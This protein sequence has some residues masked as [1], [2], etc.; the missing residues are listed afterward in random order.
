MYDYGA[1]NYDAAIGRWM[2][3]DPLAENS[4]RWTPY[5]YAYN[6]PMYFIDPDG[7]QADD[8]RINYTDKN[9]KD[10]TF[11]FNGKNADKAPDNKF[12]SD[13]INAYNYD[14]GNGGGDNL[15]A[16]AENKNIIS[17]VYETSTYSYSENG[18]IN[19]NPTGG[20]E[21]DNGV[22]MSPATVLEHEADH[23][24]RRATLPNTQKKDIARTDVGDY[25]NREEQRVI[26]GSEQK[27][28]RANGEIKSNEVTRKSHKATH[29][30]TI[31]PTSNKVNKQATYQFHEKRKYTNERTSI[32]YRKY[33]E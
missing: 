11:K 18:K 8:W 9:G 7:M 21:G 2:N 33:K 19:W 6:N 20:L 10:Q 30:I 24:F 16:V 25:D 23:V 27:T 15:K 29:V 12:V 4:R 14:V 5:N 22:I 26:T 13:F 17:D 28:A 3:I 1:R 32:D 31:S